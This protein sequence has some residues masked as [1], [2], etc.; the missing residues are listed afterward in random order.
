MDSKEQAKILN[1]AALS[2]SKGKLTREEAVVQVAKD[3]G[4]DSFIAEQLLSNWKVKDKAAIVSFK[5]LVLS[6]KEASKKEKEGEED[7]PDTSDEASDDFGF[8]G[9]EEDGEGE[10]DFVDDGFFDDDAE[11]SE[12]DLEPDFTEEVNDLEVFEGESTA[13]VTESE[14]LDAVKAIDQI[15]KALLE[16][17]GAGDG[18]GIDEADMEAVQDYVNHLANFQSAEPVAEDIPDIPEEL[19]QSYV[20][21]LAVGDK[22]LQR[23]AVPKISSQVLKGSG[24]VVIISDV[25]RP[26]FSGMMENIPSGAKA[27]G[28]LVV[29]SVVKIT[30]GD[31]ITSGYIQLQPRGANPTRNELEA[32]SYGL[33][34]FMNAHGGKKPA[35]AKDWAAVQVLSQAYAEKHFSK[36]TDLRQNLTINDPS[37]IRRALIASKKY[38]G[39]FNSKPIIQ[40]QEGPQLPKPPVEKGTKGGA[41][42]EEPEAKKEEVK[43]GLDA[44]VKAI[45]EMVKSSITE[46]SKGTSS[47]DGT[48]KDGGEHTP[49]SPEVELPAGGQSPRQVSADDPSQVTNYKLEGNDGA[50]LT[51]DTTAKDRGA[52]N[53]T[54][55]FEAVEVAALELPVQNSSF[56]EVLVFKSIGSDVHLLDEVWQVPGGGRCSWVHGADSVKILLN[57]AVPSK[58]LHTDFSTPLVIPLRSGGTAVMVKSSSVLGLIAIEAP[59]VKGLKSSRYE[60]FSIKG[61]LLVNSNGMAMKNPYTDTLIASSVSNKS[62][63]QSEV[64]RDLFTEVER[65]YVLAQHQNVARAN[66]AIRK[67]KAKASEAIANLQSQ[68]TQLKQELADEKARSVKNVQKVTSSLSA[69]KVQPDV[70]DIGYLAKENQRILAQSKQ[71]FGALSNQA[72]DTLSSWM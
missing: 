69:L 14:L 33:Y 49:K 63:F 44:K 21:V 45:I 58:K 66:D 72:V 68:V 13:K 32:W 53:P 4:V 48:L 51:A 54:Y 3:L 70:D 28:T 1:S 56:S 8:D 46:K 7:D 65:K 34:S 71:D 61:D 15:T 25:S 60:M 59:F 29:S 31:K 67:I 37:V 43:S 18:A 30:K 55:N 50:S 11:I 24:D 22:P 39:K 41:A 23:F 9:E 62:I 20:Q 40:G 36:E 38:Y 42:K 19:A 27:F 57:G 5:Q 64:K 47:P 2:I 16:E 35:D 17:A 12:E 10:D 26:V 6:A 52:S